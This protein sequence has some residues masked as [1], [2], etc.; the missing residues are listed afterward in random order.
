[1]KFAATKTVERLDLQALHH[2]RERFVKRRYVGPF[3]PDSRHW[4]AGLARQK[5][6][7]KKH[8]HRGKV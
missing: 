7:R 3:T 8:M 1:M 6:A 4:S 2:V 5:S